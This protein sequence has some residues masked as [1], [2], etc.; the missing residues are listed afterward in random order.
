MFV[1]FFGVSSSPCS[2]SFACKKTAKDFGGDFNSH[3]VDTVACNFYVDDCLKFVATVPEASTLTYQLVQLLAGGGFH[4][5]KWIGNSCRRN[6]SW[7][8]STIR[9]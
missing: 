7:R 6:L 3:P 9:Q 4:L 8:G 2:A 5:A 1:H